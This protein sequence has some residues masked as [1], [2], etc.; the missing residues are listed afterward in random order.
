MMPEATF[1]ES[2]PVKLA[3]EVADVAAVLA[4]EAIHKD[5]EL[6]FLT[7]DSTAT[8]YGNATAINILIRNLIDNAI[9]Y[10]PAGWLSNCKD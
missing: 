5:I 4:P 1:Q 7:P 3:R 6:E 2:T 9:R 8:I 10:T